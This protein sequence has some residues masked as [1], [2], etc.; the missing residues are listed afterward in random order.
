MAER[1]LVTGGTGTTGRRV[2]ALLGRD[3]FD[4]RIATRT[5]KSKNDVQFDWSEPASAEAFEGCGSAYIV[6]PTDRC[7]TWFDVET[8]IGINR[9]GR[10]VKRIRR[11]VCEGELRRCVRVRCGAEIQP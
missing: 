1:V 4:V 9:R 2:A 5:P 11:A 10:A 6:A 7:A 8:D 3:G